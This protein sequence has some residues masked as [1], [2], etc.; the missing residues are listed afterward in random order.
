MKIAVCF[1]GLHPSECWRGYKNIPNYDFSHV[2][3]K[4]NVFNINKNIDIFL[5]SWSF[6]K[7]NLLLSEYN[8]TDYL[9]EPQKD[10]SNKNHMKSKT[11]ENIINHCYKMSWGELQYSCTYSMKKSVELK[12]KYEHKHNFKYDLVLL[13][14]MDMLILKPFN[15]NLLD[16]K[17]FYV[18]NWGFLNF[19]TIK[20]NYTTVLGNL[21]LSNSKY[22]DEFAELHDELDKY[23][24]NQT[25]SMHSIFKKHIDTITNN[26]KYIGEQKFCDKQRHFNI[27]KSNDKLIFTHL[28]I[29]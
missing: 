15:I 24:N 1:Y 17:Y 28:Y 6:D 23:L 18:E 27:N 26:I 11:E 3:W 5:H 16:N 22:I 21:F 9:I 7:K 2:F 4:K 8:P 25:I 20:D 13:S 10:F 14:R 19:Y 12:K 29:K